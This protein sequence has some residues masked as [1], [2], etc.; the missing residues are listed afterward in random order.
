MQRI[1]I[2]KARATFTQLTKSQDPTIIVEGKSRY[3]PARAILIP[4]HQSPRS[5]S[6]RT[7]YQRMPA[8]RA[9]AAA[10]KEI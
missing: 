6:W 9:F 3:A 1:P 5:K 10:L 4:I 2:R 7:R 8:R